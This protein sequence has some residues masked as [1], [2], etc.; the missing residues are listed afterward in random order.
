LKISSEYPDVFLADIESALGFAGK[1][2]MMDDQ[3]VCGQHLGSLRWLEQ[4]PESEKNAVH[5]VF[6]PLSGLDAFGEAETYQFERIIAREHISILTTLLGIGR[7]K[8]VVLDLDNTLWGGVLADTQAPFAWNPAQGP[9]FSFAGFYFGLHEALKWLAKR[10]I[11][12]ACVSKN[13]ESVIRKLWRYPADYPQGMLLELNDFVTFRINWNEKVDNILSISQEL[14]ISTDSM[15]F[16][17]DNPLE[18]HKVIEH[19]PGV[20]VLGE[21]LF[22]VRS[23]LLND[24]R[25]QTPILTVEAAARPKMVKAQIERDQARKTA[26]DSEAFLASLDLKSEIRK[27]Q[28]T[29][30]LERV[31]ELILRTNQFNTTAIRF[32][33]S[34]LTEILRGPKAGAIYTLA[35]RD[36]YADYGLVAACITQSGEIPLF[37]MSCRVIG[38]GLEHALLKEVLSD[39]F[40]NYPEVTGH[41][42]VTEKN[43]P[44]R[45]LFKVNGFIEISSG[46]WRRLSPLFESART[47]PNQKTSAA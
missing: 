5:G 35:A 41:L 31:A 3:I 33:K 26:V 22:T 9:A 40:A 30:D 37:V 6:P 43:L 21:N 29:D 15:V 27:L 14:G 47:D 32:S 4:R 36:R 38:L 46:S 12:L 18:R 42:R 25:L 23:Q 34:D 1:R 2:A 20:L 10:G 16:I 7:K 17:D 13:D 39:L 11:L 28:L 19:L 45:N 8:C 24:P 44:A